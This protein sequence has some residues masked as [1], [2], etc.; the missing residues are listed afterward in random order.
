MKP[1]SFTRK[2]TTVVAL[3]TVF[4]LLP[5]S[6]VQA[7]PS[8]PNPLQGL[9]EF[10]SPAIRVHQRHS[11]ELMADHDIVGTAVGLTADGQ[12]AI[13]I[14]SKSGAI[15]RLPQNLEGLAVEVEATGPFRALGASDKGD[16]AKATRI[17][18][19][20]SATFPRPVPIGTSTGNENDC[21]AG[22][23]AAR[24]KDS[25]G[26]VY[27]LGNNHVY[28]LE[29]TAA[30]NSNILQPGLA[31]T[32]CLLT[33]ANVI[34][35]LA[36]FVRIEFSSSAS[37]MVDAAIVLSDVSLLGNATPKKGYGTPDSS[38]V[39]A[40]VGQAVQKYG[41]ST[42]LTQGQVIGIN[43]TV[44]VDYDSGKARFID[45]IIVGSK[46]VFIKA[47]DSGSLLVTR[48][49]ANPVGL[50]FAGDAKGRTTIANPI[51][52]VLNAFRVS[53]DGQ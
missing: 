18:T 12:P 10:L 52:L 51:D 33:P 5:L 6:V 22:T 34:G 16:T 17:P 8:T 23:I 27:A 37:N 50:L 41:E 36:D 15:M 4:L 28:A 2:V 11:K 26:N 9:R 38:I 31:D 46:G 13:K 29:N 44:M 20:P 24:V 49:G 19:N 3:A 48:R 25:Q 42:R 53:I 43:A 32:R 45:Q 35:A 47:G 7:Q 40:F 14:F 30:L 21:S 1:V 39:S